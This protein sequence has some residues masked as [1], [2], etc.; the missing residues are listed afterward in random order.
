VF[1]LMAAIIPG[2][3]PVLSNFTPSGVYEPRTVVPASTWLFTRALADRVGRWRSYRACY[4]A[5]S[6]DWLYRAHAQGGN[7]RLVPALTVVAFPSGY[8]PGS[9]LDNDD[10]EHGA[11]SERI[12][13]EPGFREQLL[14]DLVLGQAREG[15]YAASSTAVWLYLSRAAKNA[16]GAVLS[17]AG[18]PPASVRLFLSSPRKGAFIDSL[19]RVRGLPELSRREAMKR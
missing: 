9:Y 6:Q 12:R 15:P 14:T 10:A 18:I 1:S 11:W 17:A 19:R 7:L 2:E 4:Q 8:R 16:A 13:N 3:P 5:P